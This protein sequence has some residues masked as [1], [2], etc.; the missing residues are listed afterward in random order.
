MVYALMIAGVTTVVC[1]LRSDARRD[2]GAKMNS[3]ST[4]DGVRPCPYRPG[5]TAEQPR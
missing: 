1:D 3:R 5:S 4:P 2:L